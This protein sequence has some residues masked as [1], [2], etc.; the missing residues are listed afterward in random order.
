MAPSSLAEFEKRH[1]NDSLQLCEL[2]QADAGEWVDLGSG[3]GL[4]G[5]VVAIAYADRPIRFTLVESDKR[6]SVFLR[7]VIRQL[8]LKNVRVLSERIESIAPLSADY[9][10]ARALA[11]L[12]QLLGMVKRHLATNGVAWLM[13][14]RSWQKECRDAADEWQFDLAAFPSKT[15]PEAAILKITGVTDA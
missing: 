7:T 6:K 2:V 9:V 15:D 8:D 13:K 4:P 5:M 3:G 10:S 14:G 11:P 12:P 1:L